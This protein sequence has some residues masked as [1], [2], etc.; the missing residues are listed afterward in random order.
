MSDGRVVIDIAADD[1]QFRAAVSG[2]SKVAIGGVALMTAA[3]IGFGVAGVK[4][5]ND[6]NASMANVASLIPGSTER[7]NELKDAV[8][9][10]AVSTGK[11]T[12][13]LAGGLY[14]V[15]SAFGDTADTVK[16]LEVN[17]KAA[18][19]GVAGTA[20]AINLT[21]AVTKAYGDTSAEAVQKASDLA[22]MTV[23]LGQTTFPELAASVG[24]VTPLTNELGVSQEEL[25]ATM[26]TLTGVTGGAAEV[27]T[28]LRGALQSLMAP[29]DAATEAIK[30]A[31]YEDAKAMLAKEGLAGSLK[32]LTDAAEASGKPLQDYIGSIEGQTL[33]LALGGPQAAAYT[34]KLNAM[35][36]AAGATD[37]AFAEQ[38]TGINALGFAFQQIQQVGTTALQM[39]GD[40][41]GN[42]FGP[43]IIASVDTLKD[44]LHQ[45]V[46]GFSAILEG[47]RGMSKLDVLQG[48]DPAA[49]AGQLQTG[50]SKLVELLA[51]GIQALLPPLIAAVAGLIAAVASALPGLIPVLVSALLSGVLQIA[52]ALPVVIPQLITAL[53][54]GLTQIV[55]MLPTFVPMLVSAA[56]TLFL[57]LVQAL[58]QVIVALLAAVT[59]MIS[60]L[61][62]MLPT[63]I[64][65]LFQAAMGLFM[66]IVEALPAILTSLVTAASTLVTVLVEMLPTLIPAL[67]EGAI[68]LFMAIVEALPAI[69]VALLEAVATLVTT[70]I[71]LLPTLIPILLGAAITLFLALCEAVPQILGTL[72]EAVVLL[73]MKI[74]EL[75]PTLLSSLQAAAVRLFMALVEAVPR[76]QQALRDGVV[77]LVTSAIEKLLELRQKFL[78]A[79]GDMMKGLIDGVTNG[80]EKLRKAV[81]DSAK[82][83]LD[84]ALGFLG[85]ES[86][87]KVFALVGKAVMD[88]WEGGVADNAKQVIDA[89]ADTA[90]SMVDAARDSEVARLLAVSPG[91]VPAAYAPGLG[92]A[93]SLSSSSSTTTIYRIGDVTIPSS[94][95]AAQQVFSD[96][97]RLVRQYQRM[98]P[99]GE[100]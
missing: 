77:T 81:V 32:I 97:M 24:R 56:A 13:D 4:A 70:V 63:L 8:Q 33:A 36:G 43:D 57:G 31:G 60:T 34:E 23:R 18:T 66:A 3:V 94:D 85:I 21:S 68:T 98:R 45:I 58:P 61:V 87:S 29:T 86:P 80:A 1:Q 90:S 25:F 100:M 28:Q 46:G 96:L 20:D 92:A 64:P 53:L 91:S 52:A 51:G 35:A 48:L 17:A 14:Q 59:G 67:I 83:A 89:V 76:I 5:A 69:L 84:A 41:I 95:P 16:I 50:I 47:S 40:A 79:G 19:A 2:L 44:A 71:D 11:S 65:M 15:V 72:W 30:A 75:L 99:Q 7:V 74:V 27:S 73:V 22:L 9:D 82:K 88:G 26:A 54:D 42:A 6:F 38:T 55:G 39:L 93:G 49:A 37:A 78:D 62:G 12:E 10:M